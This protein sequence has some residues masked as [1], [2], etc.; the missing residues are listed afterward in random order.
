RISMGELWQKRLMVGGF[1][2][3]FEIGRQFRNEGISPEHL[4]DYTQM[5]CYWA[6]AN[7]EDMMK[8][9]EE[10]YREV[11][12]K[13]FGQTSFEIH[14]FKIDLAKP[15]ERIEYVAEIKKQLKI[16]ILAAS[17]EEIMKKLDEL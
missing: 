5:E 11:A 9:V 1:E 14:G 15:W 12:Q 13:T 16:D 17:R 2:K 8:L 6:Y 3:T 7:Y 10:L 4:Q